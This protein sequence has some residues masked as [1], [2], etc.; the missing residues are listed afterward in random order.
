VGG[1][2][3]HMQRGKEGALRRRRKEK[4]RIE[5]GKEGPGAFEK[6]ERRRRNELA[7]NRR[8][9]TGGRPGIPTPQRDGPQATAQLRFNDRPPEWDARTG[10][11]G[12]TPRSAQKDRL[13]HAG[14][15]SG[16]FFGTGEGVHAELGGGRAAGAAP[17]W[18][19][20]F[21]IERPRWF[22]Q[23]TW[24]LHAGRRNDSIRSQARG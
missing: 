20:R 14:R 8:S 12:S 9:R 15:P 17:G 1:E 19:R 18:T 22:L 4:R 16:G 21:V 13:E 10:Q 5:G 23:R 3:N 11:R 7:P 24:I 2:N 6:G